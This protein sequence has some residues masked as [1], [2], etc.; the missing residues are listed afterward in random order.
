M[1]M[2]V[3]AG[4][5]AA[6]PGHTEYVNKDL[7][8][9]FKCPP[10]CSLLDDPKSLRGPAQQFVVR[11][12]P[13]GSALLSFVVE[14]LPAQVVRTA[15]FVKLSQEMAAQVAPGYR[16]LPTP[17]PRSVG[18]RTFEGYEYAEGSKARYRCFVSVDADR[19]VSYSLILCDRPGPSKASFPLLEAALAGF[20]WGRP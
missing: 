7:G 17:T 3:L 10:T 20:K 13:P 14:E 11:L 4:P 15:D 8:I 19:K 2:A 9:R 5:L 18:G 16:A 1:I 6:A 12:Q